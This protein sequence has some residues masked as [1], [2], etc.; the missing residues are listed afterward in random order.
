[1]TAGAVAA[2]VRAGEVSAVEVVRSQLQRIRAL[3]GRY[4][5]VTQ[6]FEEGAMQDAQRLDAERAAGRP[7]GPLAG[8]AITVKENLD[9]AGAATTHGVPALRDA[10]ASADAPIVERLRA[11]GAIPIGHTNLPDLSLRFHT[12][13]QLYGH[14]RNPWDPSRSPGGSS[15][16]EGVA[17]ATG[18]SALGIGNDAGG[19]LRL[20]AT[21]SGVAA[22]KPSYG[23]LPDLPTVGARDLTLASQIVPVDGFL[24]RTVEDLRLALQVAAGPDHRDPRV[25]P[26]PL[27]GPC[28]G[29]P[30]RVALCRSIGG[31]RLD[32]DV[33]AG[34]EL[35]A[36]ALEQAGHAVEE[37]ALPR[38]EEAN[39]AYGQMIMTE[40][41]LAWPMLRRLL[42]TP[43]RRYIELAMQLDR[44]V[45]LAG[46]LELTALRQGLQR[47][48]AALL[49]RYPVVLGA[50]F[51]EL[52]VPV[53]HDIESL[54]SFQRC[55][56]ARTLCSVTSFLGLPAVAVPAG[57]ARGLPRG[58]QLVAAWY[59]EDLCLAA[60]SEVERALGVPGTPP[61]C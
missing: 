20:P 47:D 29:G 4:N 58:V 24:A 22:L 32:P 10:V 37:V 46:Y 11:A 21:F 42:G 48:W 44:P 7:L 51:D 60:A 50:T 19:S 30:A 16:G 54:E 18:M 57:L 53:D 1:M 17:L 40:F 35:A 38:V 27:A 52:S 9:V 34:L 15:G 39:A 6:V 3:N 45:D 14:T 25:V 36:E 56:R 23:R 61:R 12:N 49:E 43:G 13:S 8:V 26:A 55:A 31:T 59:R 41:S 2:A 5:A 28:E 33:E